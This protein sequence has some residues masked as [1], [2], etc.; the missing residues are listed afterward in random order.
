MWFTRHSLR[1]Q[2]DDVLRNA[3]GK[4]SRKIDQRIQTLLYRKSK[5]ESASETS[6]VLSGFAIVAL[7][8]FSIDSYPDIPSRDG[9]LTA[10]AILSCLLVSVHLLALL[11]SI[12]ILPEIKNVLNQKNTWIK[13]KNEE[14]L[15]EIGI[16]IEIAWLLSTGLGLFLIIL[17]LGLIIWI[18]VSGFSQTAAI[19]AIVTLV[20]VGVPFIIFAVGFYVR[21]VRAKVF[22]HQNDLESLERGAYTNTAFLSVPSTTTTSLADITED[23]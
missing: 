17:E 8:E 16:Y 13:H 10:Y 6:A 5:L 1:R 18:K 3:E 9:V 12:C 7:V 15:S 21:V 19:A 22:L 2:S 14:P 20:L 11:M 23:R 4:K